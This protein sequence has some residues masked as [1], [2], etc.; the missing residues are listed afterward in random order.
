MCLA[1]PGTSSDALAG[2][3]ELGTPVRKLEPSS[4]HPNTCLHRTDKHSPRDL[5][6]DN[7]RTAVDRNVDG[8]AARFNRAF[9]ELCDNGGLGTYGPRALLRYHQEANGFRRTSNRTAQIF[10]EL[11]SATFFSRTISRRRAMLVGN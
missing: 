3:T 7:T 6:L 10:S 11:S 8:E 9:P 4:G 5:L 2:N 1:K